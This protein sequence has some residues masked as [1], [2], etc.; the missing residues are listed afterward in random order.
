[1]SDSHSEHI[2]QHEHTQGPTCLTIRCHS[3]L[4]GDMLLGGLLVLNLEILNLEPLSAEAKDWLAA[5]LDQVKP[6][7]GGC[8]RL[9]QAEVNGITGWRL[10]VD[11][12]VEHEHRH[13]AD[14]EALIA[15]SQISDAARQKAAKTFQLLADCEAQAHGLSIDKVHFHEVGALDSILDIC[16][17]CELYCRLAPH[18]FICGPLPMADGKIC[19][20]H[21]V[22][23][24]PAPA[25]L[26]LLKGTQVCAFGG[27]CDAGELVTPTALAL[28]HALDAQ[29][30]PWPG[31]QIEAIAT[32]YG[33]RVFE[34]APN[35][36][37]FALGKI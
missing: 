8:A 23:P 3:G 34:K 16:A 25:V 26:R 7:L 29:F 28:L 17:V 20:A 9:T 14:I 5:L 27:Q 33:Q 31:F 19:C 36:A 18:T 2:H 37:I 1:M 15:A 24:A 35:G 10:A 32:V 12:P 21:G 6:G 4:S 22:L 11:L 30:G 13:L